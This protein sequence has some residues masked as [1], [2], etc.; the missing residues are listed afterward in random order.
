MG[1][2][3]GKANYCVQLMVSLIKASNFARLKNKLSYIYII[4]P[5]GF[6]EKANICDSYMIL[7]IY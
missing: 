4:I 6:V 2:N 3:L 1:I 7:I 5:R